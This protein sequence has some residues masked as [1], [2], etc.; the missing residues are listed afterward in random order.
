[1][2]LGNLLHPALTCPP[3]A[4]ARRLKLRQTFVPTA[5]QPIILSDSDNNNIRAAHWADHGWNAEW[6]DNLTR[7]RTFIPDTGT[8]PPGMTLPRT[9]RVRLN[10]LRTAVG[11]FRS[12]LYKW[13]MAFSAT[14]ECGQKNRPSTMLSSNVQ[15][16]DLPMDC[17]A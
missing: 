16:I 14:C 1:M 13:G 6:L 3:S 7:L 8:H 15:S 2:E 17:T 11:R 9:A 4:N 12:C 5:Q 10:R